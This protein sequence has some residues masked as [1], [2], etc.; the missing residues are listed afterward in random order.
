MLLFACLDEC[1]GK[2]LALPTRTAASPRSPRICH[3][4]VIP[5]AS[6]RR[7]AAS[8]SPSTMR[9]KIPAAGP[10]MLSSILR[11]IE[12]GFGLVGPALP[13]VVA[14]PYKVQKAVAGSGFPSSSSS[15]VVNL[16]HSRNSDRVYTSLCDEK[17]RPA[18]VHAYG[19]CGAATPP[20]PPAAAAATRDSC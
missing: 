14:R 2:T 15:L 18:R 13:M 6:A 12:S 9:D 8:P 3:P 10:V 4:V 1:V 16:R 17:G 20:P 5:A 19:S 11:Q 7:A